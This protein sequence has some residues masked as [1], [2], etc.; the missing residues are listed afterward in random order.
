MSTASVDLTDHNLVMARANAGDAARTTITGSPLTSDPLLGVLGPNGGLTPTRVPSAGSAVIDAGGPTGCP[1]VDQRGVARPQGGGCEIGSVELAAPPSGGPA[2]VPNIAGLRLRPAAFRGASK[3][4]SVTAAAKRRTP[5]KPGTVISYLDSQAARTTFTVSVR[6]PGIR[7]GKRC[8]KPSRRKAGGKKGRRC[9][10]VV[11]LGTFA[12]SD[13][14]GSNK[15]RFTGRVRGKRL[16]P[17]RY[18]LSASARMGSGKIS[19]PQTVAFR[20]LR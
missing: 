10:R 1:A 12:H 16:T 9:T 5:A 20:I 13:T 3:G 11:A 15:L 7:K 14:A 17:R 6:Q 4:P 18:K 2:P 19:K 8:V